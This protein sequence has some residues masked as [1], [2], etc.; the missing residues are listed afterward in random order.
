MGKKEL[1]L[2]REAHG[3]QHC[4][5]PAS[6]DVKDEAWR[7]EGWGQVMKGL[8]QPE[9]ELG[10]NPTGREKPRKERNVYRTNL[11]KKLKSLKPF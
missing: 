2:G 5:I 4:W 7:G 11:S 6:R 8:L 1:H 10:C 9:K 3:A